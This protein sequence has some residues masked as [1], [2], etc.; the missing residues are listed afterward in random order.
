MPF[1]SA[2][3]DL[4]VK[5]SCHVLALDNSCTQGSRAFSGEKNLYQPTPCCRYFAQPDLHYVWNRYDRMLIEK[6][7]TLFVRI[8]DKVIPAWRTKPSRQDSQSLSS[9]NQSMRCKGNLAVAAAE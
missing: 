4:A 6:E 7:E 9:G 2:G 5:N 8:L 3:Y 1:C